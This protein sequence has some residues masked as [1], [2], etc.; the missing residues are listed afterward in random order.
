LAR[1]ERDEVIKFAIRLL[2]SEP[3][4][5]DRQFRERL[6]SQFPGLSDWILREARA[7]A[8]LIIAFNK[9]GREGD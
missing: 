2:S 1:Q 4:I 7:D 5:N 6:R 8:R 9:V 3:D